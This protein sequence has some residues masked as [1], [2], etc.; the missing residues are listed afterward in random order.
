M[1]T[2]FCHNV[3]DLEKMKFDLIFSLICHMLKDFF[4]VAI[5]SG[6]QREGCLFYL[7]IKFFFYCTILSGEYICRIFLS[8]YELKF[9]RLWVDIRKTTLFAKGK[10]FIIH[11]W[12]CLS[13]A[14]VWCREQFSFRLLKVGIEKHCALQRECFQPLSKIKVFDRTI[15]VVV[16]MEWNVLN[17]SLLISGKT[18]C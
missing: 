11:C 3:D 18:D 13:E 17:L 9:K 1:V 5:H 6:N 4:T 16:V 15:L 7:V 8:L 2:N 12:V 14:C 10:I